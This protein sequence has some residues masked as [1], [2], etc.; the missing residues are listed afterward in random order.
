MDKIKIRDLSFNNYIDECI[1]KETKFYIVSLKKFGLSQ[2]TLA[3]LIDVSEP[4]ITT[5]KKGIKQPSLRHF[6][7]L[8]SIYLYCIGETEHYFYCK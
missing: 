2:K 1:I 5:W 6:F 7:V 3:R 8:R 4:A